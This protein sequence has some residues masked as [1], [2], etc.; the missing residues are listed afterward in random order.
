MTGFLQTAYYFGYTLMG[1]TALGVMTGTIGVAAA[2]VFV[3][4]IFSSIKID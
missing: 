2:T 4:A 3:H 1:C